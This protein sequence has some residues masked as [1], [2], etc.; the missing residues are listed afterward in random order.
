MWL[1]D[2]SDIHKKCT[3]FQSNLCWSWPVYSIFLFPTSSVY[4]LKCLYT[5]FIYLHIFGLFYILHFP[6]QTHS[7]IFNP[8]NLI[9]HLKKWLI[10]VSRPP[11]FPGHIPTI[12]IHTHTSVCTDDILLASFSF[13]IALVHPRGEQICFIFC[14]SH[15]DY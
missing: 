3:S 4:F 13:I 5:M 11:C 9:S 2:I 15:C 12:P 6:Q 14:K 7:L 8:L 1:W 10:N